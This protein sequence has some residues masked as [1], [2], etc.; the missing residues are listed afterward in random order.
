[1][2][3]LRETKRKNNHQMLKVTF[4]FNELVFMHAVIHV[5]VEQTYYL[6]TFKNSRKQLR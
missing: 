4:I 5:D 1:M 3:P 2:E 6:G